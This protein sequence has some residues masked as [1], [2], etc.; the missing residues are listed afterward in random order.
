[1][2][3]AFSIGRDLFK[4]IDVS[5][6]LHRNER[7]KW[8]PSYVG[9]RPCLFKVRVLSSF[10]A[11]TAVVFV[12]PIND[13]DEL[14]YADDTTC[15]RTRLRQSLDLF[16]EERVAFFFFCLTLL[17]VD[18]QLSLVSRHSAHGFFEQQRPLHRKTQ[19]RPAIKLFSRLQRRQQSWPW[20]ACLTCMC[21][22]ALLCR[23]LA[24]FFESCLR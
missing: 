21:I 6:Q 8:L 19:T 20:R 3:H 14:L 23:P 18:C 17:S 11:V 10:E 22:T 2:E 13:Y 1:M 4:I 12:V 16:E 5:G 15:T 7:R 9:S 24:L